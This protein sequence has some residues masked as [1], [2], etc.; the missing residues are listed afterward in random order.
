MGRLARHTATRHNCHNATARVAISLLGVDGRVAAGGGDNNTS[1]TCK[2]DAAIRCTAVRIDAVA[3]GEYIKVTNNISPKVTQSPSTGLGQQYI[4]Q[5]YLDL[6]GKQIGI[7]KTEST[8]QV[9]LP[10][11]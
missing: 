10:L 7:E 4:R 3:V 5:M 6:T 1:A 11:I 9:T 8:Y 2:C